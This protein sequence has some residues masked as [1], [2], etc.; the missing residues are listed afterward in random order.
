M[1]SPGRYQPWPN[2]MSFSPMRRARTTGRRKSAC[3]RRIQ[4]IVALLEERTLLTSTLISLAV[5]AESW[6]YGQAEVFTATVTTDPPGGTTPTGGTVSFLDGSTTIGTA[7][8]SN[9]T[10]VLS[11]TSLPVGSNAVTADYS[12]SGAF[13]S[14]VTGPG[15][16]TINTAV[17]ME[18]VGAPLRSVATDPSGDIFIAVSDPFTRKVLMEKGG[19]LSVLAGDGNNT[20]ADYTGPATAISFAEGPDG[21]AVYGGNAYIAADGVVYKVNVATDQM[22]TVVPNG[23]NPSP[24]LGALASPW[25]ST[26]TSS[27]R[28]GATM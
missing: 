26:A 5:S 27:S 23:P 2:L 1:T 21:V 20:S 4:P 10:A 9:G 25:T 15:A 17:Q 7:G 16:P 12:G 24:Y 3:C 11:T 18:S 22:T 8:L 6:T 28:V 14:S 13:E 19:Q